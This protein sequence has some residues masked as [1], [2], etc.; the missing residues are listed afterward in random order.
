[1]KSDSGNLNIGR[2]LSQ[3]F[4]VLSLFLCFGV[5]NVAADV[6]FSEVMYDLE[7]SDDGREWIEIGNTGPAEVNVADLKF[8]ENKTNH[9]IIFNKGK[10]AI[11]AGEFAV[12]ADDPVKF[13]K[14]WPNFSGNLFKSSFSLSNSGEE[15]ALK[16]LDS[17]I[18]QFSYSS[19]LGANGDG[20]SLQ[21][22]GGSWKAAMPTPGF[23]AA[24][25]GT[26]SSPPADSN[27]VSQTTSDSNSTNQTQNAEVQNQNV[28]SQPAV[29]T[30]SVK[31][32]EP[33]IYAKIDTEKTL[34]AG[35]EGHFSAQSFDKEKRPVQAERYL[36][37][38]GDGT[39]R[40]G[41]YIAHSFQYVG[42]YAVVLEVSLGGDSATDRLLVSVIPSA[43][44]IS[45]VSAGLDGGSIEL[46]NGGSADVNLSGWILASGG[47]T[48][49]FP[50][51]TFIMAGT[52]LLLGK[53]VS[54]LEASQSDSKL[55]YPN[56]VQAFA[57]NPALVLAS[58]EPKPPATSVKPKPVS[59][60]PP[61]AK[62]AIVAEKPKLTE[63]P[64]AI[65]EPLIGKSLNPA[66]VAVS[67]SS[68]VLIASAAGSGFS[69][70]W[71]MLAGGLAFGGAIAWLIGRRKFVRQFKGE[72]P[73][74]SLA[75]QFEI[76]EEKE[77]EPN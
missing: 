48:F 72:P 11:A 29:L 1:M 15:L 31:P 43:V 39:S 70:K 50:R 8:F 30:G 26:N 23:P 59:K 56:G 35:V 12:I 32:F 5:G 25:S 71:P 67:S 61:A 18:D 47:R 13:L 51:N 34:I 66:P 68:T 37:N 69:F 63:S 57:F 16:R 4:A 46:L 41:Q 36:W 73:A 54:S 49:T 58:S 33:K 2:L 76:I 24:G 28:P 77:D 45:R 74:G 10:T 7:G 14:D 22:S 27:A 21:L 42:N 19:T 44:V 64:A 17:I 38:F 6:F 55:F 75:D 40:E 3:S 53:A 60:P 20:K 52:K 62:S 65:S 9:G